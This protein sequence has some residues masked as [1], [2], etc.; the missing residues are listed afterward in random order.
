MSDVQQIN[1]HYSIINNFR[2]KNRRRPQ[3]IAVYIHC[4]LLPTK[5]CIIRC[6]VFRTHALIFVHLWLKNLLLQDIHIQSCLFICEH[7]TSINIGIVHPKMKIPSSTSGCC[8][9]IWLTFFHGTQKKK[10]WK[11]SCLLFSMLL[12]LMGIGAFKFIF[13][14]MHLADVF[15][16][17]NLHWIQGTCLCTRFT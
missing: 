16:Q 10:C 14:F 13:A 17:S 7:S 6:T 3:I 11:L 9:P 2:C 5:L 1:E 15:I 8:K 12:K 4:L